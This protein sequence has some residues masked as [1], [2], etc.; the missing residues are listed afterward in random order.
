[1]DVPHAHGSWHRPPHATNRGSNPAPITASIDRET[2]NHR[3]REEP[4]GPT[5]AAWRPWHSGSNQNCQ[6][7]FQGLHRSDCSP[8]GAHLSAESQ[9]PRAFTDRAEKIE[10]C[11]SHKEPKSHHQRG[12]AIDSKPK[13]PQARQRAMEQASENG[14]S[15]WLTAIPMS[16]YGF[17]LHKQAFRDA[18]CL[19]FGW[20]PARLA[21]HCPCGQPFSVSHAFSCPKGAM[22]SICHNA[23][24]DITAQ[25]LTEVCPKVGV[26]PTLQPLNGESFPFRSTNTEDG[27][28]LDIKAQ[29]FWDKSKQQKQTTNIL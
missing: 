13:L 11:T 10:G 7:P 20:T 18:L 4:T 17:N 6:Q 14:A 28:R 19:R 25:L 27:A 2:R 15:S 23:V 9:L 16:K 24:R 3:P 26:E 22:P 1:M 12:R 5:C 8:R 21:T 29:I